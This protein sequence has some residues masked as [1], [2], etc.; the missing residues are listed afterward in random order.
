MLGEDG[1]QADDDFAGVADTEQHIEDELE[2][3]AEMALLTPEH[4]SL[5][6][7]LSKN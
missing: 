1:K 3:R 4:F 7:W 2:L 5:G 6:G